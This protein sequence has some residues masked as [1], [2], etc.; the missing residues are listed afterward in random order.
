MPL[1]S[2][3]I[4]SL[5]FIQNNSDNP[6]ENPKPLEYLMTHGGGVFIVVAEA[7][8]IR[9]TPVLSSSNQARHHSKLCHLGR[10]KT[11]LNIKLKICSLEST[12]HDCLN[13]IFLVGLLQFVCILCTL[14]NAC[15]CLHMRERDTLRKRLRMATSKHAIFFYW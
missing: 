6:N 3:F 2:V 8:T 10:K 15:N 12:L 11:V 14:C 7:S 13:F 5:Y 9:M 1:L 4:A